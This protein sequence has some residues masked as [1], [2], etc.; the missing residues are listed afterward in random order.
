MRPVD[1]ARL[2]VLENDDHERKWIP[3]LTR[4]DVA[5]WSVLEVHT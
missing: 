4:R 1:R 2:P 5:Y 3:K